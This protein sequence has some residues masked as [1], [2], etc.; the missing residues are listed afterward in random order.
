MLNNENN[1]V[2]YDISKIVKIYKE[3]IKY[4]KELLE[5]AN[6]EQSLLNLKEV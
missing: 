1:M 6:N 3:K 5:K 4:L 2:K